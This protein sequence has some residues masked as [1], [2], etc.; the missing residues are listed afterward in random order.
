MCVLLCWCG[1][2]YLIRASWIAFQE[3]PI[4]FGVETTYLNWNTEFPSVVI[5]EAKS[6]ERIGDL[7]EKHR[8]EFF[9]EDD[10]DRFERRFDLLTIYQEIAFFDGLP[11]TVQKECFDRQVY[12]EVMKCP[13][14]DY[15]ELAKWLRFNCTEIFH[16]CSWNDVQF[17]CCEY[18]LPLDTETGPCYA[19]NNLN[20]RQQRHLDMISN[21]STG[22][23]AMTLHFREKIKVYVLSKEEVPHATS[24]D[25]TYFRMAKG[26]TFESYVKVND[27]EN[28]PAVRDID[29]KRRSCRFADENFLDIYPVYSP[30]ACE[31][32]CRLKLQMKLCNCTNFFMPGVDKEY[33]CD[34]YGLLCLRSHVVELSTRKESLSSKRIGFYC[35]CEEGCTTKIIAFVRFLREIRSKKETGITRLKLKMNNLP[36]ELFKRSVVRGKLDLVVSMGGAAGLFVGASLLSFVELIYFFTIRLFVNIRRGSGRQSQVKGVVAPDG[37]VKKIIFCFK[38]LFTRTNYKQEIH[39]T[40]QFY[41]PTRLS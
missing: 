38:N 26:S 27:I 23:G 14:T 5:C 31:V 33:H 32:N 9:D 10:E 24:S 16:F 20:T 4:N 22:P 41:Q 3:N 13:K 39:S 25:V 29:I 21:K 34:I 17:N 37:K 11:Y 18:F 12:D 19:I 7:I 1:S 35:K 40:R 15:F 28:D 6:D 8:P 2:A 30:S 36:S